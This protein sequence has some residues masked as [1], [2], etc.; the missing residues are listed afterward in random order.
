MS[1]ELD[2]GTSKAALLFA[3]AGRWVGTARISWPGREPFDLTHTERVHVVGDR[4]MITLEG[5]S[6]RDGIEDP[7]FT[8]LAVVYDRPEGVCLQAFRSGDSLQAEFVLTPGHYAWTVPDEAGTIDYAA[9]FDDQQWTERGTMLIDGQPR[10]VF[11][12]TLFRQPE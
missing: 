12:M 9:E 3:L 4:S 8:A 1:P 10:E 2:D 6:F 5:N 7:V 11:R